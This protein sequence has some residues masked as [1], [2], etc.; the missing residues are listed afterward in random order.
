MSSLWRAQAQRWLR[1]KPQA[2]RAEAAARDTQHRE[3]E[4]EKPAQAA[5]QARSLASNERLD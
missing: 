4:G 1:G 2:S 5:D 3:K